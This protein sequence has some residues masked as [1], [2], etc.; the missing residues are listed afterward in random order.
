MIITKDELF[1]KR[2]LPGTEDRLTA[3][4]TSSFFCWVAAI[5]FFI[6][7][8]AYFGVSEDRSGWNAW[9]VGGVM[10]MASM[11]RIIRPEGT[12]GFSLVNVVLGA[13]VLFSPFVFGYTNN[14]GRFINTLS[15]GTV[16]LSFSL[17]SFLISR[18]VNARIGTP[19]AW[20]HDA[21][22]NSRESQ[23]DPKAI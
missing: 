10:V 23:A 7:P 4:R 12:A 13:W 3:A 22:Q 21:I 2:L 20:E 6:S 1:G 17:L 15:V 9:I 18:D 19:D 5:W 16:L 11:I 14:T 8:W